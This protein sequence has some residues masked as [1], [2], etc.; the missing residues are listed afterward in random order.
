MSKIFIFCII[1]LSF[2][3]CSNKNTELK[4]IYKELKE[5]QENDIS[6]SNYELIDN[7]I[8]NVLNG[9]KNDPLDY[10]N[11]ENYETQ[12]LTD[13]YF[14]YI[15]DLFIVKNNSIKIV[16]RNIR[17][18]DNVF[19]KSE[20][21]ISE[22]LPEFDVSKFILSKTDEVERIL[23]Y[24][25]WTNYVGMHYENSN[26]GWNILFVIGEGSTVKEISILLNDDPL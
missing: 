25:Y 14:N 22:Q 24:P 3:C 9:V 21:T 15:I 16:Y 17:N 19:K 5:E 23:G 8:E 6:L 13:N 10:E 20:I 26:N 4:T 18:I 7:F 2:V 12:V 11:D 1:I